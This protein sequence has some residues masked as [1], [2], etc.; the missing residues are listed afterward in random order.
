MDS[1]LEP[2]DHVPTAQQVAR[3]FS[4]HGAP[5]P[6]QEAF[7]QDHGIDVFAEVDSEPVVTVD[8][9]SLGKLLDETPGALHVP[10]PH[11]PPE[12]AGTVKAI[13]DEDNQKLQGRSEEHTS[14]LS[15][16]GESRMPSSA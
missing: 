7:F 6:P 3:V 2:E 9:N 12:D 8:F 16:S 15:H 13:D 4:H 5:A 14:E 10:Q 1:F 11:L